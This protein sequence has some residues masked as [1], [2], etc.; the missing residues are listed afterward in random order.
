MRRL[1]VLALALA[2]ATLRAQPAPDAPVARHVA[3][4]LEL[5]NTGFRDVR[6]ALNYQPGA[7][8]TSTPY[9][10]TYPIRFRGASVA[11]DVWVNATWNVMHQSTLPVGGDRTALPAAWAAV[12]DSI[13]AVIPAGWAESRGDGERPFVYWEECGSGAGRSVALNTS[14][15]FQAPA[16]LL[17]VYRFDRPCEAAPR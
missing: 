16:L 7:T 8:T 9:L 3:R 13:K 11:S 12:A 15:P 2:P 1:L 5:A 14:L 6:G 4:L 10:S 17:I